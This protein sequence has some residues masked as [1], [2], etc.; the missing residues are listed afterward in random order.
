MTIFIVS[1]ALFFGI[2]QSILSI[3]LT[4]AFYLF[5]LK[6]DYGNFIHIILNADTFLKLAQYIFMGVVVGYTVDQYKTSQEQKS[7]EKDFL[8]NEYN[9]LKEINDSNVM[10]KHQYEKRLISYK[11]SL[12]RLY[13]ITNQLDT[14]DPEVLFSSIIHVL[15]DVLET[16]TV[17]VYSFDSKSGFARLISAKNDESVF[18]GKSFKLSD[19]KELQQK[20]LENDIFVGDQ[21]SQNSP[22]MAGPIYHKGNIIAII[23]IKQMA[24]ES[25]N[26]YQVNLLRTLTS[27]ISSSFIKAY[28][29]EEKIHREKYIENTEVLNANEFKHLIEIKRNDSERSVADYVL[30][31]LNHT[32]DPI[33]YYFKV[34]SMF[35]S[36]DYF[37]V[38]SQ[39]HMHV[40]LRNTAIQDLT[41]VE[42]RLKD[43]NIHFEVVD[44]DAFN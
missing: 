42:N 34:M 12:P 25:M 13:A 2:R 6:Y 33:T 44:L 40:L 35:R 28:Q 15:V 29:Y 37:G 31:K 23:L 19:H 21:W 22:A 14:L 17:S 39:N 27:L 38:D 10:I 20:L 16:E 32:E 36:T 1:I 18:M 8:E 4:F 7:I 3:I 9:E 11:T 30:L 24:F 41:Y 43:K 26:L 5:S